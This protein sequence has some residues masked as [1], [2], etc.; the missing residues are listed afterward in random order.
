MIDWIPAQMPLMLNTICTEVYRKKE[1]K[2]GNDTENVFSLS[3]AGAGCGRSVMQG[4]KAPHSAE[5]K[6]TARRRNQTKNL[7]HQCH[8]H[9][10]HCSHHNDH[11]D[12]SAGAATKQRRRKHFLPL[13]TSSRSWRM[14][15]GRR[16]DRGDMGR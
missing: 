3:E 6:N 12:H 4:W 11:N 13:I 14:C 15:Y 5:E 8:H 7:Q 2:I 16:G 1:K 10:R 9:C